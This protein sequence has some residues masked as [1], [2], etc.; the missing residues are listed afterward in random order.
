MQR[1]PQHVEAIT[2]RTVDDESI[3][4]WR[5][6]G[7][8]GGVL[9]GYA[10]IMFRG[11]GGPLDGFL[12]V[13]HWLADLGATTYA[14]NYRGYGNST[15]WPTEIGIERD[16]DA[17][18]NYVVEREALPAA[19]I[20]LAGISLG[21]GPAARLA[22]VHEPKLL[23]LFSPYVDLPTAAAQQ[24]LVGLLYRLLDRFIWNRFE[25]RDFVSTLDETCLFVAHGERDSLILPENSRRVLEAYHG[26][27]KSHSV[28]IPDAGH[29]D[30]FAKSREQVAEAIPL[31][32]SPADAQKIA[33]RARFS[34]S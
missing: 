29:N 17:V 12:V 14:F 21:T 33:F 7:K 13:Q 18:W 6:S 31:C 25:T 15:G 16:S 27:G 22:S 23:M 20:V 4:V 30:L 24:P 11:N 9:E 2:V 8:P 19:K 34:P 5:L 32:L 3:E 28:I 10:A 26:T 1:V